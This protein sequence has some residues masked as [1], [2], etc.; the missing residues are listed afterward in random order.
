MKIRLIYL[1][2]FLAALSIGYI[3]AAPV[4]KKNSDET[5]PAARVGQEVSI[6]QNKT[7]SET[8]ILDEN[9]DWKTEDDLKFKIRMVEVGE[10]YHGDEIEAKNGE[11]WLSLSAEDDKCFLKR[12][13]VTV[14]RA[15]DVVLD[16]EKLNHK[17]GKSVS[18]NSKAASIFLLKKADK[19]K[20]GEIKTLYRYAHPRETTTGEDEKLFSLKIGFVRTFTLE[21]KTYTLSVKR[22]KN[23]AN[24]DVIA[25]ILE[26]GT[27]KQVLHSYR[28]FSNDDYIGILDWVGDLDRDGKPDLYLDLYVND[29]AVYKNL[30]LSSE[31]EKGKLVKKVATFTITGC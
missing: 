30:F 19:L 6:P 20:E 16:D 31:A 22:G 4:F 21:N 29:N 26:N 24:E 9:N 25:L 3:S 8:E 7:L 27:S 18:V 23:R 15:V 1:G 28:S 11:A 13:K 17:T 2:I 12:E 5:G 10:G 14:R